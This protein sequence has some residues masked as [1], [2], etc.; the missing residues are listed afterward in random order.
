MHRLLIAFVFSTLL[1]GS[2]LTPA[3]A[4]DRVSVTQYGGESS[5]VAP[6]RAQK[7]I[8][9]LFRKLDRKGF[10]EDRADGGNSSFT[11]QF[12]NKNI[13]VTRQHGTNNVSGIAQF[14]RGHTAT[15]EQL[16]SNNT[17][18]TVQIGRDHTAHTRQ[19]GDGNSSIIYQVG[20]RRRR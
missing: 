11:K 10:F 14:G 18:F 19:I 1:L 12:G 8:T 9:R 13:A 15:H 17:A 4:G 7:K 16:G 2:G 3:G 5:V 6:R 20:G